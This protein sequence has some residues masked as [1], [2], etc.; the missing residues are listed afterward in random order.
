MPIKDLVNF[1]LWWE[2]PSWLT[3]QPVGFA[4]GPTPDKEIVLA[5][6]KAVTSLTVT[7]VESLLTQYSTLSKLI[8]VTGYIFRFFQNC[9]TKKGSRSSEKYLSANERKVAL[10]YWIKIVQ[11]MSFYDEIEAIKDGKAVKSSINSYLPFLDENGILRVGGRLE[12]A[13]HLKQTAKHPIMLPKGNILSSLL[14]SDHHIRNLHSGQ[15]LTLASLRQEY[16][17]LGA[18]GM[19]TSCIK[20][21]VTCVRHRASNPQ[22]QMGN[23]PRSR[24]SPSSTFQHTGTDFAGPIFVR[25]WSGRGRKSVKAYICVFIC[26]ASKAVHLELVSELTTSAFLAALDRFIS[27]RGKPSVIYSDNGTNYVGAERELRVFYESLQGSDVGDHLAKDAIGWSFSPPHGPHFG[28]IWESV[29]KSA[30]HHLKRVLGSN[31]FT[32][33]E[34][35]TVLAKIGACLNSRPLCPMSNNP[36]DLEVLT[37]G[38]FL[39]GRPLNAVPHPDVTSLKWNSM[40]RW[41][42]VHQIAQLFWERWSQ[43]YLA[44]LQRRSKWIKDQPNLKVGDV[45]VIKEDNLVPAKWKLGRVVE[46]IVGSDGKVRVVNLRTESGLLKRPVV[47]YAYC[48]WKKNQKKNNIFKY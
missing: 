14:I 25:T 22:P 2:G 17:I 47:N 15:T 26:F 4:S 39:I 38:H 30:K 29:V 45:V 7:K 23:L 35:M 9:K 21:C 33:E 12:K 46:A 27:L 36:D 18:R 6:E 19:I 11:G 37:P 34:M 40:D 13:H 20:K 24:V 44:E 3:Q 1:K 48:Q 43:E 8:S 31:S 42:K 5:E 10:G 28:G 32:I 41:Q 16:W